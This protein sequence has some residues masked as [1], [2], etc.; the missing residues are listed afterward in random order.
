MLGGDTDRGALAQVDLLAAL[1]APEANDVANFS[2]EILPSVL[3]AKAR[4]AASTHSAFGYAGL[5]RKGSIDSLVLTEL[6]W[7]TEELM[8]RL[9]D[10]EVLYYAREQARDETRRMHHILVDA[11]ASMRGDRA[12]FARGM[13]IATAKKLV[14]TGEDVA[15]R[16]FDSRLY[17]PH[18]SRAGKLPLAH[19]LSFKGER[20]RNPDR[21]F[22]ELETLLAL[23]EHRDAREP[24]IYVFTHGALYIPR[25]T[26]AALARRAKLA[27]V[28][29]LPSG[30]A[31]E[32]DYLDLLDA[33][34][35][36]DHQTLTSK[37]DR[38]DNA[39]RILGDVGADGTARAT[40][41]PAAIPASPQ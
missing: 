20:G 11:S 34:W 19:L 25:E 22:N 10:D 6:V 4:P 1:G 37:S 18:V 12:T 32:L 30:G 41:P 33:H 29:M 13:A 27:V 26:V 17:E 8:R 15:F 9:A 38:A 14:L 39:R 2:L 24:F 35:V 16:F 5:A 7:D 23:T 36:V 40:T 21:V 28:F 3:E 31:P